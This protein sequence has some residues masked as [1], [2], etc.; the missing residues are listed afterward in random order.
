MNNFRKLTD[1]IRNRPRTWLVTGCGGFIGSN[2]LEY[3]LVND[4]RVVGLDNFSTGHKYN[5]DDVCEQVSKAQWQRFRLLEGD[6]R[7]IGACR[8]AMRGADHVLHQAGL[9]SVPR[10]LFDP[11]T[12]VGTN[13]GGFLNMA[14][15]ARDENVKSFVY[16]ASSSSYDDHPG[17]PKREDCIGK[18]LSPHAVTTYANELYAEVFARSY[19]LPCIG[20]RYFNVFGKRQDPGGAYAAVIPKWIVAMSEGREVMINGDGSSSR[21]FCHIA[22]AVQANILAALV[23][24][25]SDSE[26]YNV[27]INEATS[28]EQ[29]AGYLTA[30]MRA[31][32]IDVGNKPRRKAFRVGDI[33][34][35]R[36]DITKAGQLLGYE[37]EYRIF[38]GLE[39]TVPWYLGRM[40]KIAQHLPEHAFMKP[41][42][43]TAPDLSRPGSAGAFT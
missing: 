5:L 41:R 20:L 37:P 28:L 24:S 33:Q 22:N 10:C 39:A 29:L 11:A 25:P 3:L 2:L 43:D 26:I 12:T 6:I 21:D 27:A 36:A 31:Y 16:A 15:A 14:I 9:G 42:A 18:P 40:R 8:E 38:A 17:L 23:P 34:H 30:I 7:D 1:E 19:G 13:V 32:G 4:Q 35:S